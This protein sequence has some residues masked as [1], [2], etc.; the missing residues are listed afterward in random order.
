MR[1]DWAVQN[2]DG[3][4]TIHAEVIFNFL[5]KLNITWDGAAV[6]SSLVGPLAG[7]LKSFQR[8]GPFVYAQGPFY[9]F[10]EQACSVRLWA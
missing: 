8:N 9:Y 4:H 1:G 3:I 5:R 2:E 10:T 6:D 7:K